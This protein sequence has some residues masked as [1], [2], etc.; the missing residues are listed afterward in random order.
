MTYYYREAHIVDKLF[1]G[2]GAIA[3]QLMGFI[4]AAE[5]ALSIA[6]EAT[7]AISLHPLRAME[8]QNVNIEY[9]ILFNCNGTEYE[10]LDK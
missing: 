3:S 5:L 6:E 8:C 10:N 1:K 7:S 9:F 4:S 2:S